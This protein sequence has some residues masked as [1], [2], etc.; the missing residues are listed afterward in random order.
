MVEKNA[1][2]DV[3]LKDCQ[4]K[5]IIMENS[6]SQ[7]DK[8]IEDLQLR[9]VNTEQYARNRNIEISGLQEKADEDLN[10]IMTKMAE[11]LNIQFD[12]EDI[13]VMHRVPTR[14]T[15]PP[16][17]IVQFKT[18]T[19]REKWLEKR[20]QPITSTQILDGVRPEENNRVYINR[21]LAEH[22]QKLLWKAR[23]YGQQVGY[24]NIWY[25]DNKIIARKTRD[26]R[27]RGIVILHE[28]DLQK[29]AQ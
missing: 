19:T 1:A 10:L 13:D 23:Q 27:S 11:T 29:L 4:S 8:I 6:L 12:V 15:G 26:D 2:L 9:I 25:Q 7:K 3:Q 17:I 24:L 14:S 16:K 28:S 21:H 20:R 5:C 18:R 22:W